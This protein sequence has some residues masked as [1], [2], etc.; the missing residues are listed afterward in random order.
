MEWVE[1]TNQPSSTG[2]LKV[3]VGAAVSACATCGSW[4]WGAA[5]LSAATDLNILDLK[6]DMGRRWEKDGL[7]TEH[8]DMTAFRRFKKDETVGIKRLPAFE[9]QLPQRG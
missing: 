5:A 7:P 9:V 4:F 1:P 6:S 3:T 8:D 2:C